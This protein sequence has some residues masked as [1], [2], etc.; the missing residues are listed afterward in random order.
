M[1]DR[2]R[3]RLVAGVVVLLMV[4]GAASVLLSFV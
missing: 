4:L 1:M 2:D 3:Q